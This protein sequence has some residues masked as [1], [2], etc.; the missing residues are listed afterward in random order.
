MIGGTHENVKKMRLLDSEAYFSI[1]N[2]L[3]RIETINI[4]CFSDKKKKHSHPLID[5]A[6][7]IYIYKSCIPQGAQLSIVK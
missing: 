3:T 7:Y 6:K 5:M 1:I 4:R 2:P